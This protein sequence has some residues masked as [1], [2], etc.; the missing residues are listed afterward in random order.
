MEKHKVFEM[1]GIAYNVSVTSLRRKFSVMDR[2]TSGRTQSGEMYRDILGVFFNY[3][4]TVTQNG[5]DRK[6]LEDFWEAISDPRYASHICVF[7]YGQKTITQRMYVTSGEQD[8][9]RMDETGN[10]WGGLQVNFIATA[11]EGIG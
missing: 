10:H 11:P 4:M 7:P 9:E 5:T 8:L 6:S 1:D 2:E 3:T